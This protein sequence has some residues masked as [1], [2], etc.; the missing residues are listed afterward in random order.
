M[1]ENLKQQ[2]TDTIRIAI[3][4]PESTGKT[5]LAQQLAEHFE[6]VWAPE[7]A[8]DYLQ[9]KFDDAGTICEPEDLLPIAIGQTKLENDALLIANKFLFC[10]TCL[11]VTK[12][13]SEIYYNFCDPV[14]DKAAR[15]QK[16]DLFFL[17]D[18]DV[19]WEKDDLRD[20]PDDREYLFD[21]F[22]SALIENNKPYIVLSGDTETRLHKAITIV[23]DLVK[24]KELGFSSYDFV[25][26]HEHGVS[27][28]AVKKQLGIFQT[29]IGKAVLERPAK[30]E[31]GILK[32][33]DQEFE[34]Y[35]QL[36]D[37]KKHRFKL[38]KFVPA[39]GA[40]SRMFKFL[41]E[42]LN[43]FDLENETINAYINRKGATNLAIFLAGMEKFPFF[44]AIDKRLRETHPEFNSWNA[45]RKNH[46]FVQVM[47]DGAEFNFCNKPKGILPFH[48]YPTHIATPIEEH[49]NESAFYAASNG[50]SNLHFTI[51]E[52]HQMQFERI[53]GKV[54]GKVE[55]QSNTQIEVGY[56]YQRKST[57]TLAVDLDNRP[58]RFD[59]GRLFFR[60]GGHGALI[61]N[62]NGLESDVIFVKNIDNVIQ[63]HIDR[64]ALYKK[65]LAGILFE[66][67]QQVFDYLQR[68]DN[69]TVKEEHIDE[70]IIFAQ[71]KL[72]VVIIEDF[73]KYTLR[74]QQI[75]LREILNRPIRVC[76]MVK[77][78]GEPGGG[79]FWV[80]DNR[81]NLSLQIVEA[82]QIDQQNPEQAAILKASTHFNPVDLVCAIRNYQGEKFDLREF[83]D[84]KSGFIVHKTK[85]G[86]DIKAY[87]LPGLWNG[88]MAKW[89][90][91]FVEVPLLT[92][93]PVKTVNDL[94][95]FAHQPQ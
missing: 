38:K 27:I 17:T 68:I 63:N 72:N 34:T 81:G 64:I 48:E 47:L 89:I 16:Y 23:N 91:I 41:T 76:G 59:D 15:K 21:K 83:V 31:D 60:P 95:K 11:M 93:N 71:R 28:D 44:D 73:Y 6:T 46:A 85:N 79:P 45:D 18:I 54:K 33:S 57:D 84:P 49:L 42:F 4:G 24:N 92:F 56:T 74:H 80:R 40:A 37:A 30:K 2:P 12:V 20:R 7:F 9:K 19:P 90:T 35:A 43:E 67:Q 1:E 87:E 14:L 88:A 22:K 70:M 77:N 65:A 29:G 51:S 3:Y 61:E 62:L 55:Q 8:R 52:A 78:E 25:Q 82:T 5:T 39:S 36:F 13:Y 75:Y 94:L 66:L 10:D 58:F 86:K 32:L 50:K 53:I 69:E 26:I